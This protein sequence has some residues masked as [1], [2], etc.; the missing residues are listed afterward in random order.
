MRKITFPIANFT[1]PGKERIVHKFLTP[2]KVQNQHP[3]LI[4]LMTFSAFKIPDQFSDAGIVNSA[5]G[6][7]GK[8]IG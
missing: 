7:V 5:L 8:V 6:I 4:P 3:T 1:Q 2:E